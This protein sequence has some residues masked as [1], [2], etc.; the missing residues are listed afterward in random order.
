[1]RLSAIGAGAL[2]AIALSGLFV[3]GVWA[4]GGSGS[5]P[6]APVAK[7]PATF[8]VETKADAEYT[9]YNAAQAQDGQGPAKEWKVLEPSICVTAEATREQ[10]A[11]IERCIDRHTQAH[12]A[13]GSE[14]TKADGE[15]CVAE[16]LP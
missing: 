16:V 1:M 10:A 13:D 2:A 12:R 4:D 8:C 7:Q 14:A 11:A 3:A 9:V 6:G 5:S 15:E